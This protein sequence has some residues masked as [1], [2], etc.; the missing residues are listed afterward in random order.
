MDTGK[1]WRAAILAHCTAPEFA[2][3]GRAEWCDRLALRIGGTTPTDVLVA[4]AANAV[5]H[6]ETLTADELLQEL[7]HALTHS[8][9]QAAS[10]VA[11]V[12]AAL[13][14]EERAIE[15]ALPGEG[16][17][18]VLVMLRPRIEFDRPFGVVSDVVRLAELPANEREDV[19]TFMRT[20]GVPFP[21]VTVEGLPLAE[22]DWVPATVLADIAIAKAFAS[23]DG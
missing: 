5:G 23:L 19:R 10:L 18:R 14:D 4:H 20:H 15:A 12:R 9:A 1:I 13:T 8:K 3:V 16:R 22:Q 2:R 11:R 7:A 21:C 17:A 6:R